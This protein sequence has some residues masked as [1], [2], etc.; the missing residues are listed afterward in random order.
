MIARWRPGLRGIGTAWVLLAFAAGVAATALWM[1]SRGAWGAYLARAEIAGVTLHDSL[2]R[3]TTPPAGLV[4]TPLPRAEQALAE[5]GDF[6]RLEGVPVP[7][8][9]T[10]VSI[11]DGTAEDFGTPVL[12][13]AIV[14]AG[15]RYEVAQL[16]GGARTAPEKLGR[17]TRLMA[18]Y[19]SDPV[20]FAQAGEAPWMRIDGAAL[21]G[22]AAAP[23]DYRLGALLLAGL[24]L[25]VLWTRVSDVAARFS[26]FAR[27]LG[28]RR[29]A[30]GPERYFA[31]GPAELAQLVGAVNDHLADERARLARRAEILSGV[32]HDLGTPATRLRLRARLIADEGLRAKVEGDI[33]R[34]TGMI[35]SVLTYTR[36]EMS[37]EAPRELSLSSLIEALV[38][39]YRDMDRPVRLR[40]T[41][42]ARIAPPGTLFAARAQQRVPLSPALPGA[43]TGPVLVTA[44]P[45][46]LGRAIGN[47]ID[48]ALKYGRHAVLS[49]EVG[50]DRVAILVEDAGQ[51]LDARAVEALMR[52][53]RRGENA[54]TTEGFGLGL[55]IVQAVAEQH[56][57]SLSFQDGAHGL[58]ARLE[59][60][61]R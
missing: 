43:G 28:R 16:A 8:Q 29:V 25:A 24:A 10:R 40:P 53:F 41:E 44:R 34:M 42:P 9:V 11:R 20:L 48:N 23:G 1:G 35:D 52:P 5:A 2:V 38:D 7:A 32:S 27:A 30:G 36:A 37:A 15:L 59:I 12:R 26:G 46:A 51:G 33:D 57:G 13:L 6:A 58:I 50:A 18:S 31:S 14:S 61:R 56:G 3:G 54:T 17:V 39:D 47:L 45:V 22:C 49:L 4:M 60:A 21:W 19:C 55:T